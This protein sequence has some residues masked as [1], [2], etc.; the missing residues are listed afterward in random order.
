MPKL[1]IY[2]NLHMHR[3]TTPPVQP[4]PWWSDSTA[5]PTGGR[6]LRAAAIGMVALLAAAA[7]AALGRMRHLRQRQ[8]PGRSSAE[9]TQ[10]DDQAR[11]LGRLEAA[12]PAP[13]SNTSELSNRAVLCRQRRLAALL[14]KKSSQH[15]RNIQMMPLHALPGALTH[16]LAQHGQAAAAGNLSRTAAW[17]GSASSGA[18]SSTLGPVPAQRWMLDTHSLQLEPEELEV[19]LLCGCWC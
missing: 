5:G 6:G 4:W 10:H 16:R 14:S 18:H 2:T 7:L 17:L 11:L 19:R 3:T 12:A 9:A 1:A 13:P 8:Q 15:S